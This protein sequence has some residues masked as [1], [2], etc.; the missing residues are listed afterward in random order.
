MLRVLKVIDKVYFYCRDHYRGLTQGYAVIQD[1]G[2]KLGY[3]D[4]Y[5]DAQ[6]DM[7]AATLAELDSKN[8]NLNNAE[9]Q[10]GYAQAV[11]IVKGDI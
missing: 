2:Y 10:L 4:G 11:A 1:L 8:P 3:A 9:F 5:D 7:Q 6:I